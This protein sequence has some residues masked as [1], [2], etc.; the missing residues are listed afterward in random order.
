V[1]RIRRN[2]ADVAYSMLSREW[3]YPARLFP[4]ARSRA[5]AIVQGLVLAS[6]A[7][8]DVPAETLDFEQLTADHV[9]LHQTVQKLYPEYEIEPVFYL[10]DDFLRERDEILRR[11]K[12]K[13]YAR[14]EAFL[15]E[16]MEKN[17]PG[18]PEPAAAA[19]P[20]RSRRR[21]TYGLSSPRHA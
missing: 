13:A 9:P 17:Q 5:S 11:R 15:A 16:A 20:P 8:D 2:V 21:K 4:E 6:R 12:T 1:I 14:L 10:N 18:Q 3:F 7:L 19:P